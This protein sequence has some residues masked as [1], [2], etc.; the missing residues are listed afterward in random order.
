M[1]SICRAIGGDLKNGKNIQ[2]IDATNL[3]IS[4]GLVDFSATSH[5]FSSKLEAE[6]MADPTLIREA[7]SRAVL[8]G[9][10]TIGESFKID[11]GKFIR[12]FWWGITEDCS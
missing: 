11:R 7:T 9:V 2:E 8:S 4:S 1:L 3:V 10:T 12:L 5:A 6:G